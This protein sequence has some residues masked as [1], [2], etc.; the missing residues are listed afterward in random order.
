MLP[1]T[2][3]AHFVGGIVLDG[4]I[5]DERD[6]FLLF[7]GLNSSFGGFSLSFVADREHDSVPERSRAVRRLDAC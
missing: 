4:D 6:A 1:L 2:R 5:F 7:Q 3:R